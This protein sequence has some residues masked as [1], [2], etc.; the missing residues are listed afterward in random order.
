MHENRNRHAILGHKFLLI[1]IITP[2]GQHAAERHT[3]VA[4]SHRRLRTGDDLLAG[5]LG[6]RRKNHGDTG[7]KK[8]HTRQHGHRAQK[9]AGSSA[10]VLAAPAVTVC[11]S[12]AACGSRCSR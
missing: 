9:A 6:M 3:L 12:A 10:S 1:G 7:D 4:Q 11:D 2:I 8:Q 5:Q